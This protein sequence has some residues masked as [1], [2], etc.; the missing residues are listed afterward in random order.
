MSA[1]LVV[2]GSGGAKQT[3]ERDNTA[4]AFQMEGSA[5]L[6]DCPGSVVLKLRRA[7]IDPMR[8]VAIVITH[9]HPD[10][11]YGLPSLVHNLQLLGRSSSL[12]LFA[13]P[14][15]LDVIRRLLAVWDL[16]SKAWSL[17]MRP[18][19]TGNG[20]PFWE[21]AGHRLYALPMDHGAPSCAI[22]WDLPGG[23]PVVYSSDTRPVETLAE[24]GRG[25][26]IF[27]HEAT[28]SDADRAQAKEGGHSTPGQAARLA[29]LA[30][31]RRLL[32]VHLTMDADPKRWVAEARSTYSGPIEIPV[33]GAIYP[34]T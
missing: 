30:G 34:V 21:H 3:A 13:Q 9:A 33:D 22:R 28:L 18:M 6:V 1:T 8:L 14:G 17:E 5:V 12:P 26:E 2:L 7:G 11:L 32:M 20:A 19:S 4:F 24:F 29:A 27:I 16:E 15:D 10:H 31:A 23:A 25:A